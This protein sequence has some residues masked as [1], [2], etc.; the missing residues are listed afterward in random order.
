MATRV[1]M[2]ESLELF[3]D[4][5]ASFP[6]SEKQSLLQCG[7]GRTTRRKRGSIAEKRE[8]E[9]NSTTTTKLKLLAFQC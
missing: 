9:V 4:P 1:F 5:F 8:N 7:E 2:G 3:T 6:P